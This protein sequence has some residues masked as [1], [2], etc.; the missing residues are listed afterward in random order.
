MGRPIAQKTIELHKIFVAYEKSIVKN[1]KI[2]EPKSDIWT[3][4]QKKLP[5]NINTSST[6]AL[7]TAALKWWNRAVE[8]LDNSNH[9]SYSV[10][11]VSSVK[12]SPIVENKSAIIKFTI[13][14]SDKVWETIKPETKLYA[15]KNEENKNSVRS[16]EVL[17]PGVWTNVILDRVMK[18]RDVPCAWVFERNSCH[19]EGVNYLTIE[20]HCKM[21][22]SKLHGNMQNE[23]EEGET[24]KINF[25]IKLLDLSRH[26]NVEPKNVKIGGEYAKKIYGTNKTATVIR[27]SLLRRKASLFVRPY[28]RVPT[29]NAIRCAKYRMRE[30]EKLSSSPCEALSY[31]KASSTYMNTI[32]FIGKDPFSCIYSSPDQVKLY[33]AYK[34]KNKFTKVSADASAGVANRLSKILRLTWL[35]TTFKNIIFCFY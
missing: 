11:S 31:L 17:K 30:K 22:C 29:A 16:Y 18:R 24:A 4:L 28:G 23:P 1:N 2:V 15:R 20:A 21:C 6:K 25:E 10:S 13:E 33:K 9:S 12:S 7:Y 8:Q 3:F 19:R 35:S 5:D 14:L 27:R 26:D 32:H 34:R